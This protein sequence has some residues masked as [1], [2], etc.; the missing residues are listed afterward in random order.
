M[1]QLIIYVQFVAVILLDIVSCD[2]VIGRRRRRGRCKGQTD[3]PRSD[4]AVAGVFIST[5][6]AS[7]GRVVGGQANATAGGESSVHEAKVESATVIGRRLLNWFLLLF[8]HGNKQ[9]AP[10]RLELGKGR[11]SRIR[12]GYESILM[13]CM[14]L[15]TQ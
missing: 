2:A 13:V 15:I 4:V 5:T 8:G 11:I 7:S 10:S 3:H 9:C 12:M 1:C 14:E 6:C